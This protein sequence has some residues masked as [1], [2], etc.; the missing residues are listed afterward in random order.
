MQKAGPNQK[1]LDHITDIFHTKAKMD[2]GEAE[3]AELSRSITK[4]PLRW[5]TDIASTAIAK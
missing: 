1:T 2:A 5:K 4:M 3:L